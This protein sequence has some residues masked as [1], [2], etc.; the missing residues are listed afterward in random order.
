MTRRPALVTALVLC[1]AAAAPG[2][3]GRKRGVSGGD[4]SAA[5]ALNAG[6]YY[7]WYIEPVA[8]VPAEFVPMIAHGRDANSWYYDR[9][10]KLKAGGRVTTLLGF[11]EPERKDPGGQVSVDD[12]VRAWPDFERLG[13]RL[14][15]PAPAFDKAGRAWLE[16]FLFKAAAK[17]LRVDFIA[18][19]WYGDVAP[20]PA[21]ADAFMAWLTQLHDEFHKPIWVTEFAGLNWDWLHH[22]ITAEQNQ[23][24]VAALE[25]QLERTPWVER[26][27]WFDDRPAN[28]FD[29]PARTRPSRLGRIYRG[30]P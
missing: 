29:D 11:N 12:A 17:H 3:A 2:P 10:R 22:P 19:H 7:T 14:G 15:S 13:L 20:G 26:Y 24:F 5:A 21:A 18:V 8:D 1:L 6:W 27:C 4:A 9:L 16:D 28:L 25:P 30:D 23:R